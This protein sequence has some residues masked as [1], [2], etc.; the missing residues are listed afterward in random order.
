MCPLKRFIAAMKQLCLL[1]FID[2]MI[3]LGCRRRRITSFT[4][5]FL[6]V[7]ALST[8]SDVNGVYAVDR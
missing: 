3:F 1:G 6:R 8:L 4:V 7:L 5:V 2:V